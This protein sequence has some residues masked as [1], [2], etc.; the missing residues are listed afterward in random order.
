MA[1]KQV[2]FPYINYNTRLQTIRSAQ[3][4]I[5]TYMLSVILFESCRSTRQ[6]LA[7][8]NVPSEDSDQTARMR[9]LIWIFAGR[10]CTKIFFLTLWLIWWKILKDMKAMDFLTKK[11]KLS[12]VKHK[13]LTSTCNVMYLAFVPIYSLLN[14]LITQN[15][16]VPSDIPTY[17]RNNW[18]FW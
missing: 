8:Q 5:I 15:I 16:K 1:L 12:K 10:T 17:A 3:K 6:D 7:I 11:I 2:H 14:T 13:C 9:R 18:S 4:C